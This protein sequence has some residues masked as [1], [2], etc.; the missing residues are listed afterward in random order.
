MRAF[1]TR[2]AGGT[3]TRWGMTADHAIAGVSVLLP[4]F[5]SNH[6]HDWDDR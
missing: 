2:G 6:G 1:V 4:S 5:A 3:W